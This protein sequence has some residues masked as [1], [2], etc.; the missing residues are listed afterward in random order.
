MRAAADAEYRAG[1]KW[2]DKITAAVEVSGLGDIPW[3]EQNTVRQPFYALLYASVGL[4]WKYVSLRLYGKN[5]TDTQYDVFRFK[6]MENEFL[7]RGKPRELGVKL[8]FSM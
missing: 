3:N 5:M 4:H 1:K 2:I 6:S 7:Q 8:T